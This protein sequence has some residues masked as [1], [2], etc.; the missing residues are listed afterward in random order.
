MKKILL[1]LILVFLNFSYAQDVVTEAQI[2]NTAGKQR[3][4]SQIVARGRVCVTLNISKDVSTKEI[5]ASKIMF[6]DNL[7]VIKDY[8]ANTLVKEKVDQLEQKWNSYKLHLD[9]NDLIGMKKVI[10]L[11]TE[12][13]L[14]ADDVVEELKNLIILKNFQSQTTTDDA[15]ASSVVNSGR[16]RYLSQRLALYYIYSYENK[17]V[18]VNAE[19]RETFSY[20]DQSI[21]ALL[22]S[23]VNTADIDVLISKLFTE[24]T[25]L[26]T[27]NK[28]SRIS[29]LEMLKKCDNILT[30]ADK[31]TNI[32]VSMEMYK[33]LK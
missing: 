25:Q 19:I 28:T 1:P 16:L 24:W 33:T 11:N 26:K 4:L 7:K 20:F 31:I 29:P 21:K 23:D 14:A 9:G 32:Y 12:V 22:T 27:Q 6:E 18:N 3:L 13:L 10:S 15:I 30:L 2:L 8:A 5:N 17:E